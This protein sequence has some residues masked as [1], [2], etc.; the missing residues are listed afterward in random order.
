MVLPAQL[1]D[2]KELTAN[3]TL[4]VFDR[5]GRIRLTGEVEQKF[6]LAATGRMET[7]NGRWEDGVQILC[8]RSGRMDGVARPSRQTAIWCAKN[9]GP[10]KIVAGVP[11][12]GRE[13]QGEETGLLV[14][15]H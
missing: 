1:S 12:G 13:L 7:R 8:T 6:R 3:Y 10:V 9:I 11:P 14:L 15:P 2:E 4:K 5:S